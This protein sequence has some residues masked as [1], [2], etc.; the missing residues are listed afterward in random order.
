MEGDLTATGARSLRALEQELAPK[1]FSRCNHC[2]LVNL[3]HVDG[4]QGNCVRVAGQ[5]LSISRNRRKGFLQDLLH[6]A[7]G[8]EPV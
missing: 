8:G 6:Y 7:R 2:Y 5:E 4:I 1:G 3:R